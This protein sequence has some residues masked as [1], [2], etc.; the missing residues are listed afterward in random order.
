MGIMVQRPIDRRDGGSAMVDDAK[1]FRGRPVPRNADGWRGSHAGVEMNDLTG[2]AA[3]LAAKAAVLPM[4]RLGCST[5]V[6]LDG[7]AKDLVEGMEQAKCGRDVRIS[8]VKGPWCASSRAEAETAR[9]GSLSSRH[10]KN[11]RKTYSGSP[12]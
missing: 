6:L 7:D 3:K 10:G 5:A 9:L 4:V 11:I 8:E 1:K 2:L 12:T